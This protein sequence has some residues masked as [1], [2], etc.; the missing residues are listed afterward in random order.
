MVALAAAG[1]RGKRRP[2][3][4]DTREQTSYTQGISYPPGMIMNRI[5]C[6]CISLSFL[7]ACGADDETVVADQQGDASADA[8]PI[9]ASGSD[10]S[11]PEGDAGSAEG[12]MDVPGD[13]LSDIPGHGGG[14]NFEPP[15]NPPEHVDGYIDHVVRTIDGEYVLLSEYRGQVM[16]I[17]N[18]ASECAYTPQYADLQVLQETYGDELAILAFPSNE[19]GGQ[20]PGTDEEIQEFAEDSYHVSFALFSKIEVNGNKR[21]PVYVTLCEE[22]SAEMN[23]D[24]RWNFTK[25]IV[26]R[27]GVPMFRFE[28]PIRPT[29]DEFVEALEMALAEPGTAE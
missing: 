20:E 1:H 4:L 12:S 21:D 2:R 8:G 29:S 14:G 16:I 28:S 6:V 3:V 18:V 25:F 27:D 22:S 10:A 24:I 19:F 17:V 7:A 13:D 11:T 15:E 26:G 9:E 5:V 23:G